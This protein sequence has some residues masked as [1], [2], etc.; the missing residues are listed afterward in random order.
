MTFEID[1]VPVRLVEFLHVKPGKGS[2][3]VRTKIKNLVN[4]SVQ[5]RTFRAGESITGAEVFKTEM[6]YTYSTEENLCFMNMETF[7]EQVIDRKKIDN[8]DFLV[9]GLSCQVSIWN[10]QVI[11]V[12]LP[13]QYVYTVV[14]TPPNF[15]GNT[16]QGALKPATLDCG[17]TV[18][19]PMFIEP[20]EK[21]LVD[22][23]EKRYMSRAKDDMKK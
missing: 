2:A 12:S 9:E 22:T 20:G 1:G 23:N 17:A 6:Q 7:E 19:V 15:K 4:G 8:I 3:F 21:I 13:N 18:N 16:A 5:E 10:D 14:D 11:D